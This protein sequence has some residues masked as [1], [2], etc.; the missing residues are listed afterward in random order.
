M[1]VW[2]GGLGSSAR[3]F[4]G[5][6]ERGSIFFHNLIRRKGTEFGNL[7]SGDINLDLHTHAD[8]V[9]RETP[10]PSKPGWKLLNPS[11]SGN[12]IFK[13]L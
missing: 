5:M 2:P 9:P 12:R 3:A 6:L 7:L 10:P 11:H 1:G 8:P 4:S 13:D